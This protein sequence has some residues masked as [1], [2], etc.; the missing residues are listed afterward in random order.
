[1]DFSRIIAFTLFFF[2]N[3]M[4]TESSSK[5]QGIIN[6][7]ESVTKK[8][9]DDRIVTI[10]FKNKSTLKD[11]FNLRDYKGVIYRING[12]TI[13]LTL[14]SMILV[15]PNQNIDTLYSKYP[16]DSAF[17]VDRL[18]RFQDSTHYK[19]G[20]ND[21]S[22]ID[23]FMPLTNFN[24]ASVSF[25][26]RNYKGRDAIEGFR[27]FRFEY[28]EITILKNSIK[29]TYERILYHSAMCGSDPKRIAIEN[30]NKKVLK[31]YG[32]SESM[33][34]LTYSE[35]RFQEMHGEKLDVVYDFKTNKTI[36]TISY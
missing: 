30:S 2:I 14:D 11:S 9:I 29:T 1:M 27:G 26:I 34:N 3:W 28:E 23:Y 33:E 4:C 24:Q 16:N 8:K 5:K 12:Y 13:P 17:K 15:L 18:L 20:I 10:S 32:N 19:W 22:D 35:F 21:C 36:V 7:L 6:T 25:L 31:K